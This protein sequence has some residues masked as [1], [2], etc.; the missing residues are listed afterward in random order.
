MI[1]ICSFSVHYEEDILDINYPIRITPISAELTLANYC[2]QLLAN[3]ILI[4]GA[5]KK[6]VLCLKIFYYYALSTIGAV[7]ILEIVE[8]TRV[9]FFVILEL[10]MLTFTV[11]CVQI[12]AV[13]LVRSL[14]IKLESSNSHHFNNQLHEIVIGERKIDSDISE[15]EYIK[16]IDALPERAFLLSNANSLTS[17]ETLCE[18]KHHTAWDLGTNEEC[19]EFATP[20][21]RVSTLARRVIWSGFGGSGLYDQW[22]RS[23]R[24]SGCQAY[25]LTLVRSLY[26]ELEKSDTHQPGNEPPEIVMDESE[27]HSDVSNNETDKRRNDTSCLQDADISC[28]TILH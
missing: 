11:L 24:I 14:L 23:V 27:M 8:C 15:N 7:L 12:Y 25:L 1:G 13:L 16:T 22:I 5:H 2:L 10:V 18:K 20:N 9:E 17:L 21:L 28:Q 26:I 4:Y 19:L 3:V 6:I